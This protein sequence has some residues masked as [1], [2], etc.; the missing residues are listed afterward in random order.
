MDNGGCWCPY[1]NLFKSKREA[2]AAMQIMLKW[3]IN[4]AVKI[5]PVHALTA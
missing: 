1:G 4:K 3:S 2:R 5:A